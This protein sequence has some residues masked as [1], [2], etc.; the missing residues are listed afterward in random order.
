[1]RKSFCILLVS[2]FALAGCSQTW[3]Q[4]SPASPPGGTG[5][6]TDGALVEGT[7][8]VSSVSELPSHGADGI[9]APYGSQGTAAAYEYLSG[10]RV[11]AGDRLTIRVAGESDLTAD[12]LVDGSGD[13][14][15]PYV[16]TIHIGG[17]STSQVEH[18]IVSRLRN[19]YLRD[20]KVSVQ[21]TALRPF[22]ILGEVT[23]SGSFAYQSGITIQN[24][25]AIAG[26]YSPRADQGAVLITRKNVNGTATRRVPVTTQIYPGDIIYVRERW[27]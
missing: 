20:P 7:N 9:V 25:I 15:M 26:G 4:Y 17:L 2:S 21:A 14:S 24:A 13:I 6:V 18:L 27:F 5:L 16:Q 3:E 19:G 10:Y 8:A 23:T 11:G 1:V 12:Y 22:Y